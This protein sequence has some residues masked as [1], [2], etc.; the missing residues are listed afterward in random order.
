MR[1]E[2]NTAPTLSCGI[3]V[4]RLTLNQKAEVRILAGQHMEP[5]V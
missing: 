5:M 4:A 1:V 3:A 2:E